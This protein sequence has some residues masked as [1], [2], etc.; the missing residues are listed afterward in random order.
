[1]DKITV[2]IPFYNLKNKYIINSIESVIKQT[3]TNWEL[4]IIDDA[5]TDGTYEYVKTY[6]DNIKNNKII[7]IKNNYN[8]G[9]YVSLNKGIQISTGKYITRLDSDDIY[10]INK[11]KR[12]MDIIINNKNIYVVM[13][14]LKNIQTKKIKFHNEVTL[15]YN[16]K[17][18]DEIGYYDSVLVGADT[19]FSNRIYKKYPNRIHGIKDVLYYVNSRN[20]SLT[21]H[22]KTSISKN[23]YTHE[24]RMK[25]IKNARSWQ[26]NTDNLYIPF[27]IVKRKSKC[28]D[29]FISKYNVDIDNI[30]C[31]DSKNKSGN[32]D[33]YIEMKYDEI[34]LFLKYLKK[35]KKYFEYGCGGSTMLASKLN[36]IENIESVDNIK[37]FITLIQKNSYINKRINSKTLNINYIDT[38]GDKNNWGRP[39]TNLPIQNYELYQSAIKRCVFKPDLI[40]ID[41]RFR[42]SCAINCL[43]VMTDDTILL[44]HDYTHR[45]EYH[46]LE[47]FF[48]KL[49]TICSLNVFKRKSGLKLINIKNILEKYTNVSD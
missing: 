38:N 21:T 2:L 28:Y 8:V 39:L 26:S 6:L 17:V 45:K 49:E 25:Y 20:N 40:L 32:F 5:S 14:A 7:L 48:V 12:Q 37:E 33:F 34:L 30:Q 29:K 10:D 41:G 11:L 42:V 22:I 3:Y 27:P 19:E 47:N 1:M 46:V 16:R 13:C 24:K 23:T 35:C 31:I 43:S 44:I 4:I 15:L 36:N 18:I 9:C